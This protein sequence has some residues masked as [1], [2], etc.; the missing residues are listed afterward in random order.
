MSK[1]DVQSALGSTDLELKERVQVGDIN[2]KVIRIWTESKL[3]HPGR[4]YKVRK[5]GPTPTLDETK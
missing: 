1:S 2:V 5:E 3:Y 4:R